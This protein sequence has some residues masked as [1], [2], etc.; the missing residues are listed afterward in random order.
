MD[1]LMVYDP[2]VLH[3]DGDVRPGLVQIDGV[4]VPRLPGLCAAAVWHMD[5]YSLSTAIING[6]NVRPGWFTTKE[7]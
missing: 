5:R 2:H 7:P 3:D 4:E 1:P 6:I